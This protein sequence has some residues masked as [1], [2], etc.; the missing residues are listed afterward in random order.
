[1][2]F[3]YTI[4]AIFLFAPMLHAESNLLDPVLDSEEYCLAQNIYYES[5]GSNVAD[6]VA[7]SM[8]VINRVFDTRFPPTI[9][10]VVKQ[11]VTKPSWKTGEQVPV[12]NQCQFSW[13][14]DGKSDN[15]QDEEAWKKAQE[16]AMKIYQFGVTIDVAE[17]ATH[18]HSANMP[19][20]P[21][22]SRGFIRVGRIG[23]HIFYR[24]E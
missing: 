11:A 3:V 15:P 14:C 5:R 9:C 1:M 2:K 16:I 10:G 18:Y 13:Y 8:V 4:L 6:Q 24:W 22:W 20:Y 23:D 21:S 12:R 7:V 19:K 17:G